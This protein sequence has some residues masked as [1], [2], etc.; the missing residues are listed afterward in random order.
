[1]PKIKVEIVDVPFQCDNVNLSI[2]VIKLKISKIEAES[3]TTKDKVFILDYPSELFQYISD[4]RNALLQTQGIFRFADIEL[5]GDNGTIKKDAIKTVKSIF[6]KYSINNRRFLDYE[7]SIY[8]GLCTL[9]TNCSQANN[10]LK[11]GQL[12]RKF[13][14][15]ENCP[16][17]KETEFLP[18]ANHYNALDKLHKILN[19]K[20]QKSDLHVIFELENDVSHLHQIEWHKVL[21]K[22]NSDNHKISNNKKL[23]SNYP[24][25]INNSRVFFS[26]EQIKT[27]DILVVYLNNLYWLQ[28]D[29]QNKEWQDFVTS[30]Q[31]KWK[32]LEQLHGIKVTFQKTPTS[33]ELSDIL[34]KVYHIIIF[35]GHGPEN[36]NED[37]QHELNHSLE[38]EILLTPNNE[39]KDFIKQEFLIDCLGKVPDLQ[40]VCFMMCHSDSLAR[41]LL[42]TKKAVLVVAWDHILEILMFPKFEEILHKNIRN[43][44][45]TNLSW[46]WMFQQTI[47]EMQPRTDIGEISLKSVNIYQ[48]FDFPLV[49]KR[50]IISKSIDIKKK[51]LW[52]TGSI[53]SVVLLS[54][55]LAVSFNLIY[56][57]V[58]KDSLSKILRSAMI[59]HSVNTKKFGGFI[60]SQK[61]EKDNQYKYHAIIV[62]DTQS[63]QDSIGDSLGIQV[64]Y[65]QPGTITASILKL[66]WDKEGPWAII[67][68][69]SS[70]K[71]DI[72]KISVEEPNT[73]LPG[74]KLEIW[75]YTKHRSNYIK[76][77]KIKGVNDE[78]S[79]T[80][81][82]YSSID[83][84]K[85]GEEFIGSPIVD[86]HE[87]IVGIHIKSSQNNTFYKGQFIYNIRE[88]LLGNAKNQA[89]IQEMENHQCSNP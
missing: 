67:E 16:L 49:F 6:T 52:L 75:G 73:V 45:N 57:L 58:T 22:L 81:I 3:K 50:K 15:K 33:D 61:Q 38:K 14:K 27:I 4:Y 53:V 72:P 65:I 89:I 42:K 30:S 54:G 51:L 31:K 29:K 59:F 5:P 78:S 40:I 26:L 19:E 7:D 87:C 60:F 2:D 9:E 39:R 63:S 86:K 62:L 66:E 8:R 82:E 36:K 64:P 32:E 56:S 10:P 44:I 85:I 68:F 35:E 23:I 80:P 17:K 25:K 83:G 47:L 12:H 20:L 71:I 41:E 84:D 24:N 74:E 69:T 88:S 37:S 76:E 11:P 55:F 48:N 43:N 18:S 1:M 28:N 46:S 79:I 21:Q 77:I 34:K 70:Q 13:C